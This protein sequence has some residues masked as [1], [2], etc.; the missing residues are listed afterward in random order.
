[1]RPTGGG[2]E[3]RRSGALESRKFEVEVEAEQRAQFGAGGGLG[4]I[5]RRGKKREG[6]R[7]KKRKGEEL[8]ELKSSRIKG[9]WC[10]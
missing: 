7:T 1:M 10:R 2:K 5:E 4:E 6:E 8:K 3:Q 9:M